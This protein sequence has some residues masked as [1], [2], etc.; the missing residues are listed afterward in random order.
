[1]DIAAFL[2]SS[3]FKPKFLPFISL[4]SNRKQGIICS[5]LSANLAWLI[6]FLGQSFYFKHFN[7]TPS[8]SGQIYP[9]K[10]APQIHTSCEKIQLT[11]AGQER[12][13]SQDL[14]HKNRSGLLTLKI[15]GFIHYKSHFK[16]D[17]FSP[18]L[19]SCS[20]SYLPARPRSWIWQ[21]ECGS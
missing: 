2:F 17:F 3:P 4:E 21:G 18:L 8:C 16:G 15:Q 11:A 12:K 1:M 9:Q 19:P 20:H 14:V 6:H 10:V 5:L 7:Q 13:A